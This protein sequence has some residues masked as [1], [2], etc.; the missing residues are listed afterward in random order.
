MGSVSSGTEEM[1]SR[2]RILATIRGEEVDRFPVWLK[3]TNRTWQSGQPEPYSEMGAEELLRAA[4]CDL[5]LGNWAGAQKEAPHVERHTEELDGIRRTTT[6]TPD[7]PIVSETSYDPYTESWH[8]TRFAAD[9][10][11][12]LR[13]ARWMF[14]DTTYSVQPE[15]AREWADRQE[16]LEAEG[17]FTMTGIGP[18]PLMNCV[19]HLC[20]PQN[21]AYLMH[22]EAELFDEVIGLMHRDRLRNLKALLPHVAADSFW[23]TENT[24]TTLISPAQFE[25]YCMP[26]LEEYGRLVREHG[27]VAVHHMC[28]LLDDLLEMIDRLPAHAN[29]AYTTPP[30]GNVMLAAGRKR[31]ASKALIGGTNATLWLAP[32]EK[33]VETVA[34]DLSNCPDRR[35][36]FLTS[37]GVLPPPVDFDKARRAVAELKRL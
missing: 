34:E 25:K 35:K 32:V 23:L 8:P 13:R 22:D 30:V 14:T 9:T 36:I 29:E 15:T 17:A 26:Q 6:E 27:L 12:N 11:E 7:G 18:S 28:G 16:E 21:T 4:G 37:A 20:G 33:I 24:T 5:M 1:T 31:M 2:E 19:Q 10:P 3:M